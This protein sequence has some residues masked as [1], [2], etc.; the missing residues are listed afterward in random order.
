MV[1]PG[2]KVII[3]LPLSRTMFV[4][5]P[6]WA[7][8]LERSPI[9]PVIRG[10]VLICMHGHHSVCRHAS[11]PVV[12]PS[13]AHSF[14]KVVALVLDTSCCPLSGAQFTTN[15]HDSSHRRK[16]DWLSFQQLWKM[17]LHISLTFCRI[18]LCYC[19]LRFIH[20]LLCTFQ[21]SL[22]ALAVD[23]VPALRL[24]IRVCASPVVRW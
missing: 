13:A 14:K 18:H 5:H 9:N 4:R 12:L 19:L 21:E 23:Q 24:K 22:P 16:C 20:A 1:K 11:S 17:S 7:S 6:A 3:S 15:P 10:P 2:Q 8:K